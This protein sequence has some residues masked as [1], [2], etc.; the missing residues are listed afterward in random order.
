MNNLIK[1][2]VLGII[3]ILGVLG[4]LIYLIYRPMVTITTTTEKPVGGTSPGT[5]TTQEPTTTTREP[6]YLVKERTLYKLTTPDKRYYIGYGIS[7]PLLNQKMSYRAVAISPEYDKPLSILGDT[8]R[9]V[10]V[11]DGYAIQE[12]KLNQYLLMTEDPDEIYFTRLNFTAKNIEDATKFFF[13][14]DDEGFLLLSVPFSFG[15]IGFN[16]SNAKGEYLTI[17]P[18]NDNR[19]RYKWMAVEV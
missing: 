17:V 18:G 15:Y 11:Q 3:I 8:Y 12:T 5:T 6:V 13:T 4:Y 16:T 1:V 19:N 14:R 9:F 7:Y 10:K 2:L